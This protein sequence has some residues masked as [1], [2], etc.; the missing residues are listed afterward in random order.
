M[1]PV[2]CNPDKHLIASVLEHGAQ[3]RFGLEAGSKAELLLAASMLSA[4]PPGALLVCNG[5]KDAAYMELVR[6]AF[7]LWTVL[8][9]ADAPR[10]LRACRRCTASSW[11]SGWSSS[12]SSTVSWR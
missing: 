5:Y 11:A 7:F 6:L 3:H 12:W 4:Q 10:S 1:F 9:H 8:H 2:K